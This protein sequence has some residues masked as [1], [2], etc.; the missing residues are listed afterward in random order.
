MVIRLKRVYEP[1]AKSDGYRVLVE[2][3]W[4]RGL[5]KERA[6]VDLWL[7]DA[8]SSTELRQVVRPRPCKLDGVS[9][10]VFRRAP[11]A[12]RGHRRSPDILATHHVVTFLYAARDEEHNNAVVLREF[13]ETRRM[14]R[15]AG[16]ADP[17]DVVDRG[18]IRPVRLLQVREGEPVPDGQGEDVDRLVGVVPEEV[19][20]EDPR[21]SGRRSAPRTPN[22]GCRAA[23]W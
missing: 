7:K 22:G 19:G 15:P 1:A 21:L 12:A 14:T 5:S 6:R 23:A 10:E 18:R 16:S 3:L 17:V 2:R 11:G 20:A 4:P 9:L 13:L 8:G